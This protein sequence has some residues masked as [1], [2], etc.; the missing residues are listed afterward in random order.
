MAF[1]ILT[2][3]ASLHAQNYLESSSA[4]QAKTISEVTSGLRIVNAGDD[5]AGLAIANGYASQE[6]VL[7]QGIQNGNDGLSTLQT[8]DGGLNNISQLLDRAQTLATESASGTFA[9]GSSGRTQLN[10]EFQS[11]MSE[12]NRQAQAIGLDKGGQYATNLSAFIGGGRANNGTSAINNG[13]VSVDLSNATVDTKSLGLQGF[14]AGYQQTS[15]TS[16][17]TGF[18][19]LSGNSNTNTSVSAIITANSSPSSTSFTLSGTGFSDSIAVNL[20]GVD[21]A[22]SLATAIN[23]GIAAAASTNSNLSNANIQAVIH[24]GTDGS[25]QLQFVSSSQAFSVAAGD[26]TANAFLGNFNGGQ[27]TAGDDNATTGVGKAT[28]TNSTFV[29]QGTQQVAASTFATLANANSDIQTITFTAIDANGAPQSTAVTLD[30]STATGTGADITAA[31]AVTAIN[32]ALQKTNI[33]AL[34]GIYASASADG[35]Q[36]MFSSGNS[37]AFTVSFGGATTATDGFTTDANSVQKS[38]TTGLSQTADIS[39]LGGAES[40]VNALNNAV[41]ALGDSQAAV[42]KGENN[43]NYA[44]NLAQSQVTNLTASESTIR[45]ADLATEAANLSKAQILVQAGT[46]AL[47]QAN[48]APQAILTLLQH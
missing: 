25:Q 39:T 6:A 29:A 45:D 15:A 5:A 22:T 41:T 11:V 1:S 4:F 35:T 14:A 19:D 43:F 21:D 17:D 48:S 46:A 36:I 32:A 34:Q 8:I 38:A 33:G 20:N 23:S 18:Y 37:N 16:A 10:G 30:S 44:I 13:S 47:A 3:I 2:N 9:G 27:A 24:T 12:I 28:G 40:A 7:T 42:G 26:A 31:G